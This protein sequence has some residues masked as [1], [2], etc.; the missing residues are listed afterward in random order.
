LID[1]A[2]KIWLKIGPYGWRSVPFTAVVICAYG[3]VAYYLFLPLEYGVGSDGV[4]YTS[5]SGLPVS[6]AAAFGLTLLACV[7]L[8]AILF[9][10][11]RMFSLFQRC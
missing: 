1:V 8:V 11:T 9:G 7:L 10:F 3:L 2:L 6:N 4:L 5:I